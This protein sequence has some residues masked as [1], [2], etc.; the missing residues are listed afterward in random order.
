M[1]GGEIDSYT[2]DMANWICSNKEDVQQMVGEW[3][4][5]HTAEDYTIYPN[6]IAPGGRIVEVDH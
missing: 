6:T 1:T 3:F 2:G 4:Q 5:H